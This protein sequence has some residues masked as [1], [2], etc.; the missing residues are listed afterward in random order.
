MAL[1]GS[2]NLALDMTNAAWGRALEEIVTYV[3]ILDGALVSFPCSG[4]H[5]AYNPWGR[6]VG[7]VCRWLRISLRITRP[8]ACRIWAFAAT[9][10]F[11]K[12]QGDSK[13][14]ILTVGE[15]GFE[16]GWLAWCLGRKLPVGWYCKNLNN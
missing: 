9:I 7:T 4:S 8:F 11:V 14:S 6:W 3:I 5:Y 13:Y 15:G 1:Y 2:V 12:H 16:M 10:R